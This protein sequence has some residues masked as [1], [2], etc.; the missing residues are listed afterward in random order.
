M[1][2]TNNVTVLFGKPVTAP[3]LVPVEHKATPT[4]INDPF[5]VNGECYRVTA[6]SLGTPHG[7]VFVDDVDSIDVSLL[8]SALG[9]H[10]LFPKGASIVFIEMLDRYNLKVRLW[11]RGEGET[12]FMPE[13]ACVAG[14]TAIMLHKVLED[15]ATII[16][17]NNAFQV[18]W[19]RGNSDVCLTGPAE[20]LGA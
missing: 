4:C 13:A 1:Q 20:L 7:A 3:I 2:T 11:Q 9:T 15:R 18:E 17:G 5:I 8:G 10:A 16:M 6:M 19:D 14:T 12:P